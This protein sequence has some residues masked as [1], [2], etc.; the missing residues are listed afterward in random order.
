[1]FV[2]DIGSLYPVGLADIDA[3]YAN[4]LGIVERLRPKVFIIKTV[5]L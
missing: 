4:R 5:Y 2:G 1:M 3:L